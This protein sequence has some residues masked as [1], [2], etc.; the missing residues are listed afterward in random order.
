MLRLIFLGTAHAVPDETHDNTSLAINAGER[1]LL[2]DV[3]G[4]AV[5]RLQQAG[6]DLFRVTD[7]FL[8]HFHP[9]HVGGLPSLL[10]SMW[11]L[12]RQ[13]P[14]NI[15]GLEHTLERVKQLMN[16]YDWDQWAG[17]FP[18]HFYSLP[19]ERLHP[20]L[21]YDE[22]RVYTSPVDHMIPAIGLRV[23]ST[24]TGKILAYSGDTGPCAA[25]V[26]LAKNADYLIHEASGG[27]NGHSSATQAGGIAARASVANLYLVHTDPDEGSLESKAQKKFPGQVIRAEDFMTISF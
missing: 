21:Q 2:V 12:G 23:E 22:I 4:N 9:D 3:T 8:T 27:Y 16:L 20:A 14:L 11:L 25:V 18:L 1:S 5:V 15:Y 10:M 6:I 17:F 24:H 26:E 13:E 19:K 7:I